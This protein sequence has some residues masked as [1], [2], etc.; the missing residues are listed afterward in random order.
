[1]LT[2]RQKRFIE[3]YNGNA[4][5]AA[6]QAGY[7][8]K[9]ADRQAHELM[10]K[11]G[12]IAAAIRQREKERTDALIATREERQ[13]FWTSIMRDEDVDL[14]DRLRAAELLG[15]S[16]GDFIERVSLDARTEVRCDVELEAVL[17]AD[18][19]TRRLLADLYD[20]STRMIG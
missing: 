15:R 6:R 13:R 9:W 10:E 19:E 3:A 20:R 14:R 7:S 16:E 17:A 4:S 2:V 8:P 18:P 5:E 11:N 1:M 12:E